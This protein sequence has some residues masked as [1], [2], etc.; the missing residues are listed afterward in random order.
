MPRTVLLPS[1]LLLS[2]LAAACGGEGP[3]RTP[4]VDPI[5]VVV[6]VQIEPT[7]V[8]LDVGETFTL[9]ALVTTEITEPTAAPAAI[10]DV[11]W[12][13]IPAH[14]ATVAADGTVVAIAPGAAL[15]TATAGGI[16]GEALISVR[17]PVEPPPPPPVVDRVELSLTALTL[18]EGE[19]TT[20]TATP[21]DAGGAAIPGLA[22]QWT[23]ADEGIVTV[24]AGGA[25]RGIRAGAADVSATVHGKTATARVTVTLETPFDLF[26]ETWSA[27]TTRFNW[28]TRDLRDPAAANQL[29]MAGSTMAA[30]PVPSPAGDR[31]AFTLS[32]PLRPQN[33]LRVVNLLRE[34]L[35]F[36][37][38]PGEVADAAWSADGGHIAF[39][40]R[41]AETGFDLWVIGADGTGAVNLTGGLGL[42]NETQPTWAPAAMGKLAFTRNAGGRSD[43]WT[44]DA[45]GANAARLTDG[46]ADAD[47]AWSPDGT[48]IAFQRSGA[49]I[50]GD[51]FFVSPAG[52]VQRSLVGLPGIQ[53]RPAWSPDGAL[54]AFTSGS[55]VYTMR[56][57]DGVVSRRTFDGEA[58]VELRPGWVR[59]R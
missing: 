30:A 29:L 24:T 49:A 35:W 59:R 39:A 1:L 13:S 6:D 5:E 52:A 37:E 40:V 2:L 15:I 9:A 26:F 38:F 27:D 16:T 7:V 56:A 32:A 21:R 8:T 17:E 12:A 3:D 46:G 43:L 47:P 41:S 31:I 54:V 45:D 28:L 4:P 22:A 42:G 58:T 19:V 44:V 50:F 10:T 53:G 14:V 25:L 20:L 51:L 11:T 55:D 36:V 18:A 23:S 34:T 33:Q 48:S 57:A